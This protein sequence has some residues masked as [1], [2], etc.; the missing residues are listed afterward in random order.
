M[1]ILEVIPIA[2]GI[3]KESLTYYT[4]VDVTPG[5]L[6]RVPL[7]KKV[8]SGVVVSARDVRDAKSEIKNADFAIRKIEKIKSKQF[9]TA[10]FIEAVNETATYLAGTSGAVLHSLIPKTILENADKLETKIQS[11]KIG[12]VAEKLVVQA[13]DEERYSTYKSLIREE[14][15]KGQSV[16]FCLPTIQ[17]IKKALEVL[18]KGIEQYTVVCHNSLGKK[19]ILENWNKILN[20]PH[21]ILIIGTGSYLSVPRHDI[22][23]IIIDHENARTYKSQTRPFVDIRTFAEILSVKIKA[24]VVFGD[25]LLRTET[26]ARHDAGE[27]YEITPLKF[28]SLSTA[29]HEIVN[30]RAEN[31]K[32]EVTEKGIKES[33][34][35]ILSARLRELI[36]E[37]Q[38]NGE[39]MFFFVARR[40]LFPTTVCADCGQIVTCHNCQAPTVLHK[41]TTENFF[42]CHRCGERRNALEKCGK[43]A[44]WRLTTLGIGIDRV[45]EELMELFP[46]QKIFKL[47]ADSASTHK[48]ALDIA[49]KFY[50]APGSILV[51]TEMALL[52]L[53]ERIEN[54]AVVS[55]DTFF[56]I[57]DFRINEKILNILLKI[58]T[59][60]AKNVIIQTRDI[61][62]TLF[63]YAVK[64][65]LADFYKEEL[66]LRKALNYPPNS[67][68]IK[69]TLNGDKR[70]VTE[71]MEKL[72]VDLD[73][74]ELDVFPA[75]IPLS[76]GKFSMHALLRL[77]AGEWVDQRLLAKLQSL[78][79]A[80]IVNVDPESLL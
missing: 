29:T 74:Y 25:I 39:R 73:P 12:R 70:T 5:T 75:F 51:G 7:R 68:L 67:T 62:R 48:K 78:S 26:L 43:C 20:E 69:I 58:R 45:V 72:H 15:A 76:K 22:S 49:Q 41:S 13:S 18:P 35:Q 57:P 46:D 65:N 33:H 56:S 9:I 38:E 52:Y 17:D 59:M 47:D 6:V 11:P 1:K 79:P 71:A 31:L 44:G 2:R 34:F 32:P 40:G 28:R 66:A 4:G 54:S 37:N 14:F 21:P 36:T 27:L 8:I 61:E 10:A 19:E 77:P 16:F 50:A 24:K 23:T 3:A 60:S 80:F 55:M 63:D 53:D 42:L 30:M 64:G